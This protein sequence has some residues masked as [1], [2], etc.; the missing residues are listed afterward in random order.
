MDDKITIIEGPPPTFEPVLE[1]WS[2]GLNDTVSLSGVIVTR[3]RTFN[4]AVLVER[5]HKAW[6]SQ[7][8]MTLEYRGPD[9]LEH[10]S[11][12]LAARNVQAEAGD[13]LVLWLR[14]TEDEAHQMV[15][16]EDDTG[17]KPDDDPLN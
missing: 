13:V 17:E 7:S 14:L 11:L 1:G 2:L 8:D 4:G 15:G 12:I 16:R 5:C 6:Y 9:G 3:L 10:H